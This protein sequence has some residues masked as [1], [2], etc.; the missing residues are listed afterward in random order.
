MSPSLLLFPGAGSDRDHASLVA[1]AEAVAP[2]RCDR[3]DFPYRRAG[4]RAP[5]RAPVLVQAVEDAAREIDGPLVLGGRSMGGRMCSMAVA[6]GRVPNAVGLV[7]VSYPLHPPGKPD[8]LRVEHLPALTVPCL[9]V[10][11]TKD[12]F[13]TR[14]ELERW[15]ATIPGAVTHVWL[16]GKGHDLRNA[17][18][19]IVAAVTGWLDTTFPAPVT[20][21]ARRPRG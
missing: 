11:G 16:D 7:L 17:D 12:A 9:F 6:E 8:R 5:D 2:R 10:H 15:T 18:A 4:R 1:L 19:S 14:D 21:R 20:R 3:V 13:G